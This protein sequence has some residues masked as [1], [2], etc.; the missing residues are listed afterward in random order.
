M[1]A[2]AK[3]TPPANTPEVREQVLRLAVR[4]MALFLRDPA[5][6]GYVEGTLESQEARFAATRRRS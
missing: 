4:L 6:Y 1:S 2:A 5:G 3:A